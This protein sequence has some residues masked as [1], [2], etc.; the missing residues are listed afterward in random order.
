MGGCLGRNIWL[1][2]VLIYSQKLFVELNIVRAVIGGFFRN[3]EMTLKLRKSPKPSS[4][5]G[6][7]KR[8][9]DH[10]LSCGQQSPGQA[11]PL[12][13]LFSLSSLHVHGTFAEIGETC[14]TAKVVSAAT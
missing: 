5:Q 12:A 7:T 2:F 14:P 13:C 8:N 4:A 3:P 9:T 1:T 11:E 6:T 10:I